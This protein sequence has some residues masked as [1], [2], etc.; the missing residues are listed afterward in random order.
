[1]AANVNQKS[2]QSKNTYVDAVREEI[3][4]EVPRT[5]VRLAGSALKTVAIAAA[6]IVAANPLTYGCGAAIALGAVQTGYV[7]YRKLNDPDRIWNRADIN[8]ADA[9][10][11]SSGSADERMNRVQE[12][13]DQAVRD[14]GHDPCWPPHKQL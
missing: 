6:P 11:H 7:V 4:R 12:I 5:A 13:H 9:Y 10:L 2:E 1:M 3:K 8:M 14:T